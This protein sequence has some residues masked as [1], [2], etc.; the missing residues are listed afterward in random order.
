MSFLSWLGF[1]KVV[2]EGV[3]ATEAPEPKKEARPEK[4][5][6]TGQTMYSVG[7]TDNNRISLRMGY[8]E[9]TMNAQGAQNLI[10]QLELF[11]LQVIDGEPN[12]KEDENASN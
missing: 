12:T 2:E 3:E 9:I 5:E 4:D 1:N 6:P 7:L 8:S 10:D 11:K